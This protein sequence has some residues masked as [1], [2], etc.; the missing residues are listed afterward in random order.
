M[1]VTGKRSGSAICP[2]EHTTCRICSKAGSLGL[3][4]KS[5]DLPRNQVR[6]RLEKEVG[7]LRDLSE[8]LDTALPAV[9]VDSAALSDAAPAAD[10][11]TGTKA[12]D[13]AGYR[14]VAYATADRGLRV[15]VLGGGNE[16]G[17]SAVLVEAGGTRILVDAGV[18]P[19]ADTPRLAAPPHISRVQKVGSTRSL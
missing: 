17:G 4:R 10:G 7:Q 5:Q 9:G 19:N 2:D 16:I 6:T 12:A 15:E 14:P 8:H 18:R 11:A 3:K 13:R 1:H